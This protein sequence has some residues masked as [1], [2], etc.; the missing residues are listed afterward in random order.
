MQ[1]AQFCIGQTEN[2]FVLVNDRP[3][4]EAKIRLI[5]VSAKRD[6]A[7]TNPRQSLHCIDNSDIVGRLVVKNAQLG[8]AI[9]GHRAITI[10]MV[11]SKVEPETNWW[12]EALDGFELER[13]DFNREHVELFLLACHFGKRFADIAAGDC[14]LAAS[15]QHL[16][17]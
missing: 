9:I 12:V 16:S 8:R 6:R 15:I 4:R 14:P 17:D 13:A 3:F 7:C 10:E 2:S 11:G 1:A 5:Y